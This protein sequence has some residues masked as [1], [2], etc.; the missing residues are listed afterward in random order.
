M[1]LIKSPGSIIGACC[2]TLLVKELLESMPVRM[3]FK[4][5]HSFRVISLERPIGNGK[6]ML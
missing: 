1:S 3:T 2:A 6:A 5:L 4:L